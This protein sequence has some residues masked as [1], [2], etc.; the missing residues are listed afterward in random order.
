MVRV[1][2]QIVQIEYW[3]Q[4]WNLHE[5]RLRFGRLHTLLGALG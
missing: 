2:A 5:M 3:E 4:P 1:I